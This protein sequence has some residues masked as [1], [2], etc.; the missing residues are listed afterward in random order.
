M[1]PI[2]NP[3]NKVDPINSDRVFKFKEIISK[4]KD[5]DEL[6][7]IAELLKKRLEEFK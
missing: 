1:E 2:L 6:L 3:F 4:I 5:K 7:R